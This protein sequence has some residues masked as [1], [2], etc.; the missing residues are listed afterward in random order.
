MTTN[1][2]CY[3]N[4]LAEVTNF[5]SPLPDKPEETAERLLHALWHTAAG[6]PVS[7]ECAQQVALPPLDS[8]A[9]QRLHG[10]LAQ[11]RGGVP[12]AHLT[13]RQNFLGL[14]LLASP[15]ALIPRKETE[16]LGRAV[17]AKLKMLTS[18]R[19]PLQ[20]MDLCTGSGNLALAYASHEPS[21]QVHGSDISD[22][23]IDLARRNALHLGLQERVRFVEGDIFAPFENGEIRRWDL[24]SCNP[25]YVS[26][27]KVT[28]MHQEI[29]AFEPE[30]AFNGGHFG[31]AIIA[32]LLREAPRFLKPSSWLGFEVG[33]GQGEFMTRRLQKNPLFSEVESHL[34]VFGNIRAI[35]VKTAPAMSPA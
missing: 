4:L 8:V 13:Q 12:L 5:W 29:S 3:E 32:A 33:L 23:A 11:K 30:V 2:M 20:V 14:E 9:E 17:L 24:I 16:I 25:P 18:E 22:E 6:T 28:Q 31:L 35:L 15:A 26:T 1:T 7:A 21:A 19:G 10:L 34:D 27:D